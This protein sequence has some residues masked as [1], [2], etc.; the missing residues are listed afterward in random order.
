M[1]FALL[2]PS[3]T[4]RNSD[5]VNLTAIILATLVFAVVWLYP[6]QKPGTVVSGYLTAHT[7]LEIVSVSIST[8]IFAIGWHARLTKSTDLLAILGVGFLG[9][10]LLDTA[11]ILS[12][13][14]MPN[15]VTPPSA[16]KSISFWFAARYMAAFSLLVFI[17]WSGKQLNRNI[18]RAPLLFG[19]LAIVLG[20]C[21]IVLLRPEIVPTFLVPGH[22]LTPEKISLEWGLIFINSGLMVL[23]G[24]R[25]ESTGLYKRSDLLV[26]LWFMILSEL[27]F[28][29]YSDVADIFILVGHILKAAAYAYLYR[30]IVI[31]SIKQPYQLLSDNQELLQQLTENINQALWLTSRDK[32]EMLFMSPAY[33]KIWQRS[34]DD[35]RENPTAWAEAVL[36]E[37]REKVERYIANQALGSS[38]IVYR[39]QR[40]DNSIRTIRSRSF[41]IRDEHGQ[42][43]RIA[44]VAEDITAE[45]EHDLSMKKME[46]LVQETQAIAHLGSWEL[47]MA[48]QEITWSDETYNIYGTSPPEFDGTFAALLPMIHPDD[49]DRFQQEYEDSLKHK[50]SSYE[51]RFRIVRQNDK[52]VRHTLNYYHHEWDKSGNIVRSFGTVQDVTEQVEAEQNREGLYRQLVQ[53]QKMEAVGQLTGG[54]AHDFNNMLGAILG[55]TYLLSLQSRDNFDFE[56]QK[57]YIQEITTAGNRAKDL[58]AQML[59]FSRLNPDLTESPETSVMV[60]PIVKEVMQLLRQSIPSTIDISY[61]VDDEDGRVFFHPV[62]LHQILMNLTIN[63]RDASSDGYGKI[64]VTVKKESVS[65]VCTSCQQDFA[66]DYVVISVS[67][68]GNGIDKDALPH[69]FDPFFT[70]KAEHKGTGMGL[71][72]VHGMVHAHHG[73]ITVKSRPDVDGTRFQIY[74]Q[75]ATHIESVPE[76]ESKP[77]ENNVEKKIEGMKVMV[78]DDEHSMSSLLQNLLE[79]YGASVD[80]FNDPIRALD[81]FRSS[82][83]KYDLVI[84]DETMPTLS[85]LDLSRELLDLRKDLPIILCTGFS[86]TVNEH[87]IKEV[88]ITRLLYKPIPNHIFI[89]E[90][91]RIG[92][93]NSA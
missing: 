93:R 23:V 30:S 79:H 71:S 8:I 25:K 59:T 86:E 7:I 42:V 70:T 81:S 41:P 57:N 14:G 5:H 27:C 15:W 63:S 32:T 33:E 13:P 47:D 29:L 49:R 36:P 46:I 90:V 53:A 17:F 74:M 9:V 18:F 50:K 6:L 80:P 64:E 73:H 66:G 4:R 11:H 68:N 58:I 85:G 75:P 2:D 31:V 69:I 82:P 21:G 52:Q 1:Q 40:P 88:G 87:I 20:V 67:D 65:T 83:G 51:L 89:E 92:S 34:L 72:V 55:Y 45:I 62:H 16:D 24:R 54:I 22:G 35:M 38:S 26:C 10:A 39:I 76:S 12:Y 61:S 78:V 84:T 44:G 48:T 60:Q 28:T 56:Q 77:I 91:A 43:D 19:V 37:D 3:S